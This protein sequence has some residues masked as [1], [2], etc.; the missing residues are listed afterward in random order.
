MYRLLVTG[1]PSSDINH[2]PTKIMNSLVTMHNIML[3]VNWYLY[4]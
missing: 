4:W 2:I 1:M 3:E